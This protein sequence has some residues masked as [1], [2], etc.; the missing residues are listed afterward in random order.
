MSIPAWL[1]AIGTLFVIASALGAAVSVYRTQLQATRLEQQA[2]T[3]VDLEAEIRGYE[4]R[5]ERLNGDLR[6]VTVEGESCKARISVLEDLVLRRDT[7]EQIRADIAGLKAAMDGK[8]LA[9]LG[10]IAGQLT[11][12]TKIYGVQK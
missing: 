1:G 5:E 3:I 9:L 10:Q 11:E 2:A 6:A 12:F 7:D 4:R 8:V